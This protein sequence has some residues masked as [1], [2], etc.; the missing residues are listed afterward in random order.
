MYVYNLF[1]FNIVYVKYILLFVSI[2]IILYFINY[3][4]LYEHMS[5]KDG[6]LQNILNKN[7]IDIN[8]DEFTIQKCDDNNNCYVKKYN[9]RYFNSLEAHSFAKNKNISNKIFMENNIPVPSHQII[10]RDNKGLFINNIDIKFPCVLKPIDGMQGTDVNTFI[11]NIKQFNKILIDLLSKYDKIMYE[12]QVYG[13]NYR[14]FVFNNKVMDVIKREQPF[15]IGNGKD[16]I[17]KLIEDKNIKQKLNHLYPTTNIS[18]DYIKD[19]G[20]LSDNILENGKKI[21]I[22]NTINFHNGANPIRINLE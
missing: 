9:T 1:K 20:Y 17:E 13:D 10:D 15:V 5:M 18:W 19:N 22:T 6:Y 7:G 2:Y 21:F 8:I 11:K 3:L 12:E 16:T 4:F 14:I